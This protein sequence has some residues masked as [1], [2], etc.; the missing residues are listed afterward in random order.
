MS[1]PRELAAAVGH[2]H[3]FPP[4]WRVSRRRPV[5]WRVVPRPDS[6]KPRAPGCA[7]RRR[8][9]RVHDADS[10]WNGGGVDVPGAPG[11]E[12]LNGDVAHRRHVRG[13]PRNCCVVL[14]F[15]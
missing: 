8:A 3:G 12:L 4:R 11:H 6:E 10:S 15:A 2:V 13:D 5:L 9:A 14:H 1:G 7:A